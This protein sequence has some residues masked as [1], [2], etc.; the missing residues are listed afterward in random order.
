MRYD[1][2]VRYT[3]AAASGS[4]HTRPVAASSVANVVALPA[5]TTL[6]NGMRALRRGSGESWVAGPLGRGSAR[7]DI[8]LWSS[9]HEA[10]RCDYGSVRGGPKPLW[11]G[12]YLSFAQPPER[13]NL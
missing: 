6:Y 10:S 4:I 2:T 7:R 11:R 12:R 5:T 13:Q 1:F 9:N 8:S 3:S